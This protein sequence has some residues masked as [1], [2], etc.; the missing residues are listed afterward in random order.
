M[1]CAMAA[2]MGR[3]VGTPDTADALRSE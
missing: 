3:L 2:L 1:V